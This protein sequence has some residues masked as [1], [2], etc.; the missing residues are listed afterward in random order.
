MGAK[1]KNDKGL[2]K[3][4]YLESGVFTGGIKPSEYSEM[5]IKC[6][7]CNQAVYNSVGAVLDEFGVCD[8]DVR[9]IYKA[10]EEIDWALRQMLFHVVGNTLEST[11]YSR[12]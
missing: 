1:N 3:S 7:A 6:A 9:K 11:K 10:C 8:A 5:L 2:F 12:F 4:E